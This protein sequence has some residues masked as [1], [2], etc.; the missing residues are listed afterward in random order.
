M[1]LPLRVRFMMC[2][3]TTAGQIQNE[4]ELCQGEDLYI[5]PVK[6]ILRV[7]HVQEEYAKKIGVDP[8]HACFVVDSI[9]TSLILGGM[10]NVGQHVDVYIR[11]YG[12]RE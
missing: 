8:V 5:P 9:I 1:R 6:G 12:R 11:P 10:K 4:Q 2:T 7:D 3:R